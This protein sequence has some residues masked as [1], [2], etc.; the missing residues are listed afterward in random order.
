[1]A[2]QA[3]S[4]SR[5][6]LNLALP[7]SLAFLRS[8]LLQA[9]V[10][11]GAAHFDTLAAAWQAAVDR[12]ARP[13]LFVT[14]AFLHTAWQHLAEPGDE[15]WFVVVRQHGELVGLL[16]LVRRR[17][18]SSRVIRH[19]LMHMGLLGGDRPGLVHHT[20]PAD[21]VWR[22]ALAALHRE[23][24]HWQALDLR[25]LDAS[26]WPVREVA[27]LGRDVRLEPSTQAGALRIEGSWE[28]YLER[29]SR[30]TRQGYKRS[31]RRLLEAHPDLRIDVVDTP[32][33]T[34]A[35]LDR[36]FAID[37]RSWKR[38]A[39][40]EFWSD[41]REASCL[42]A[43]VRRL[44][45]SGQASVWLL[46]AGDAD[47]AGLVRLR[48]RSIT[49][50]R[51]ATYDPAYARFGP[52]TYLCMQAVRR[53]FEG[54]QCDESDVLGLPGEMAGRPAIHAWYPEVRQTWRLLWLNPPW[55]WRA[56]QALR[57]HPVVPASAPL[58]ALEAVVDRLLDG[59][60]AQAPPPP[61]A[62]PANAPPVRQR[63]PA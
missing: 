42:R 53:S 45:T 47:L 30:N 62:T 10:L 14:P 36:Y 3:P 46:A 37:A 5:R 59:L 16:P 17:E 19:V 44:A 50:E 32:E 29:R 11:R 39:C 63:E 34:D 55:W 1:L 60:E 48:H 38:E 26:A 15:A 33:A 12:M 18:P 52:S 40:V 54:G 56:L 9:D 20:V 49:Y 8:P 57:G 27:A 6:L 4:T 13:S 21:A 58:P 35:A 61:A 25:E 7:L 23:R 22:A 51:C 43:L 31:E 41:P 24:C 2:L 28:S